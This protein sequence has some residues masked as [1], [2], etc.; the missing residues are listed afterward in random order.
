MSININKKNII[1]IGH[2]TI[3]QTVNHSTSHT[4]NFDLQHRMAETMCA[5]LMTEMT[6]M[7]QRLKSEFSKQH[8]VEFNWN[9]IYIEGLNLSCTIKL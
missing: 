7:V 8:R 3:P 4:I 2:S 1:G 9:A 6:K 5:Q